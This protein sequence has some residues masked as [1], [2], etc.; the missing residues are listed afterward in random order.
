[1]VQFLLIIGAVGILISG[2]SIGA[3]TDGE[4]ERGNFYSKIDQHKN[5]RTKISLYSGIGGG[6]SLIAAGIW[7]FF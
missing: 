6:V 5:T 3:W 7:Y 2:I 1:M 4:R